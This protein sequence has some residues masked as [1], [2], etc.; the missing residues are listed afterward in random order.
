MRRVNSCVMFVKKIVHKSNLNTQSKVHGVE[1]YWKGPLKMCKWQFKSIGDYNCHMVSHE[2][3]EFPCKEPDCGYIR[4]IPHQVADHMVKHKGVKGM[5]C[6]KVF[7][8]R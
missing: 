4:N 2:G 8:H 5:L 7:Y 3:K 6:G 1:K